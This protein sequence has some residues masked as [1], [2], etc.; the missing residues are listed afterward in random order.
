MT[1]S[2]QQPGRKGSVRNVLRRVWGHLRPRRR[3][4]FWL[5]LSI[6]IL[7]SF[8][9]VVSIGSVFPLLGV[10]TMPEIVFDHPLVQPIVQALGV[11]SPNE[12]LLPTIIIFGIV[13]VLTGAT[14]LLTIYATTRYSHAVGADISADMYRRTLYQ[15]YAVHVNEN[16]STLISSITAKAGAMTAQILMPVLT[17]LSS[18]LLILGSIMALFVV[19]PLVTTVILVVVLGIYWLISEFTRARLRRNGETIAQNSIHVVRALQ[20]GLGGIRDIIIDGTQ[21]QHFHIFQRA[22][23]LLRLANGY[24]AFISASP[25]YLVETIGIIAIAA[26]AYIAASQPGGI[27]SALPMLGAMALAAQRLLPMLQQGYAALA[28]L[29]GTSASVLDVLDA[30]DKPLP[31]ISATPSPLPFDTAIEL[32]RVGFRYG[33]GANIL[34]SIDLRLEKGRRYGF[35]GTTG[36]GKSTLLDILMGLLSPTEGVFAIDGVPV[37]DENRR[38]WQQ[39]LAHVP[40]SIFLTDATIAENIA[41][42]VPRAQIDLERVKAAARFAQLA[43]TIE[44]WPQKYDTG[45]GE[46]GIRL[47]GGQRQRVGIARALYKH[48]D[49]LILDEATSAL[50]NAT[51]A[52]VMAAINESSPQRTVLIVAHRLS[53]LSHCDRVFEIADGRLRLFDQQALSSPPVSAAGE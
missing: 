14:R 19:S 26:L 42:G 46:R 43:D 38:G 1:R 39:H 47:S 37:T 28:T 17:L 31:A 44:R 13:A 29:R 22:D 10:L 18:S 35:V 16:S 7:A 5:V 8:A 25:R 24:N 48:A 32:R 52:A 20:E 21:E 27:G 6:M 53:T 49:V 41:F 36:S 15:P 40:Q 2:P 9:E 51:E 4:Q 50:D 23:R 34:E 12:L 30:L 11:Q 45:T 3:R 33:E